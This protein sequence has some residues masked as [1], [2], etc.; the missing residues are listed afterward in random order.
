M[1]SESHIS[2]NLLWKSDASLC[3]CFGEMLKSTT[4]HLECKAGN[5]SVLVITCK[6]KS[7]IT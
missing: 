3:F 5:N 4:V 1:F 6:N 2:H 7:T